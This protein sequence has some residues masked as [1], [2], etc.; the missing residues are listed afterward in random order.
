[1]V[2]TFIVRCLTDSSSAEGLWPL[3]VNA[4]VMCCLQLTPEH[5]YRPS[6][7]AAGMD[8]IWPAPQPVK[9]SCGMRED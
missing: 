5:M 6:Q 1:M 9:L 8:S 7:A 2:A 3:A 4:G